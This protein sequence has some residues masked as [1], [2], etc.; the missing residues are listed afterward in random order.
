MKCF[1]ACVFPSIAFLIFSSI[2]SNPCSL[3][4]ACFSSCIGSGC[5]YSRNNWRHTTTHIL[6]IWEE[7]A[8]F[9]EYVTLA[10]TN[11]LILFT[12]FEYHI[13][14]C[15]IKLRAFYSKMTGVVKKSYTMALHG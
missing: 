15:G 10:Y 4:S 2:F 1:T 6:P 11:Y 7:S 3:V 14:L 8:F 5:I 9:V 13:T 12:L